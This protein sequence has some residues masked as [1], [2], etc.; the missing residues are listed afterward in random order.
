MDIADFFDTF[1]EEAEELLSDMEQHL[2]ELDVDDPDSEQLNAIFRAAHSIKGGAGTFGFTVL[3]KTTHILENLLDYARKG[4]LTLRAD[5]VDTFL[6]AKDIMHEQ[7]DAYRSEEEPNQEAFERICQ[8]LQ[9]IA[10]DEIGQQLDGPTIPA[11]EPKAAPT[12]VPSEND[13]EANSNNAEASSNGHLL[14]ALLNVEDKDRILLV[15]ELEQLGEVQSQSGDAK[16][17]EVVLKSSDSADDIEAVMCFIIEPDQIEITAVEGVATEPAPAEPEASTPAAPAPQAPAESTASKASAPKPAAKEK[18][19]KAA[20]ESSSIRV[21]VDKVDQIINLVG[22]LIITQSMLDQTVS[23]L[24]DQSVG[25][26]SLQNGMSLLQRNARDLQEAVMSIR[27]IPMEFV[28]SR[29]PR[30]V[31]DTAGKLGKEI[32]L[33]T[34]G[35]STELDK[36]LVERI[37]DPLTHL[38]RNSLDHG[39]EMPDVREAIGK[40]RVGKLTLSARHQGGNILIEVR[41]D[42]AGMDRERLLAKARENGL[43]VSDTMSDEEVFQLIFA[44]G[45]S[46]ANEVTDVSGRGVGMDVVKRNIQSMGGRVEIQSKLGEGTNTRIVLPLTLAILD[47]MSIKVGG[48]TFILPLSTVL[49]SLQ[50]AKDDMYAMAGDDVVIKVRDEYLPV[51]AIHEV[52]NVENA[53]TDPTKSIAVI[54]Q[55]E[56][57]RYAMLVDELIGQQQ[58]VVK[59]LEDNYRKVPGISAAT[60]LGDGSVALILDITG[61]HRLSRYKKEAG[62]KVVNNQNLSSFKEAEPS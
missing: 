57:R 14:V 6:E 8:T 32:E 43:N 35:K 13:A 39:V 61:L 50:P 26:A 19:K 18:P 46:T 20:A 27:M 44:P 38:V 36:S 52:L 42:G 22:E 53:I 24:E 28:F 47:G 56:G 31:R 4:E 30:V 41:D 21:S 55:G 11:A 59:N 17:Y 33:I 10:L 12:P 23:D 40:P 62:K 48:E 37:T 5:L 58:V 2:L 54:V 3:Q 34:E 16:R 60:I 29:F 25:N 45:F 7:L 15:E 49:E 9:Q 1:F 51:I